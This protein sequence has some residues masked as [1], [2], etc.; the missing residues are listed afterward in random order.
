MY[1]LDPFSPQQSSAQGTCLAL[2]ATRPFDANVSTELMPLTFWSPDIKTTGYSLFTF[3]FLSILL[4]FFIYWR[5]E[6]NGFKEKRAL[7]VSYVPC[8]ILWALLWFLWLNLGKFY[9]KSNHI[10]QQNSIMVLCV[11]WWFTSISNY[12]QLALVPNLLQGD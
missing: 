3:H 5:I 11:F 10:F 7:H 6:I 9:I 1:H 2:E 4:H 8:N 12:E